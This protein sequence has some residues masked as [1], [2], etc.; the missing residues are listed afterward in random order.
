MINRLMENQEG[1]QFKDTY[2]MMQPEKINQ[3]GLDFLLQFEVR[4]INFQSTADGK[5]VLQFVSGLLLIKE[6]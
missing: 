3:E 2:R 4:H 5:T 1:D 6:K